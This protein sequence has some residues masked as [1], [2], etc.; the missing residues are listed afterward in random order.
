MERVARETSGVVEIAKK[1]PMRT[2]LAASGAAIAI[3]PLVLS[4]HAGTR[5][6]RTW[7]ANRNGIY[8][9][10]HSEVVRVLPSGVVETTTKDG[11][12]ICVS[13]ENENEF[14]CCGRFQKWVTRR[15]EVEDIAMDSS[16]A[17]GIFRG[18][19]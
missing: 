2:D 9:H 15:S 14:I 18:L 6:H 7:H 17:I 3:I 1:G 4:S 19:P 16:E 13:I 12:G 8:C 5:K 11:K 10:N